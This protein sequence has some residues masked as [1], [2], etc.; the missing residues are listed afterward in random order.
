MLNIL[1]GSVQGC[2]RAGEFKHEELFQNADLIIRA[3]A[4]KYS[5]P[6]NDPQ[7]ITTGKPDSVI[8]F[9]IV[10]TLSGKG[11]SDKLTLAG[12]L[13]DKDDFNDVPVPY[14]F[15]RHNGRGGSCFANTY[16]QGAQFLLFLKKTDNGYTTNIS[17]LGPTN[18]QLR[19]EDDAWLIWVRNYLK[20]SDKPVNNN[21]LGVYIP[22][23]RRHQGLS[24]FDLFPF[25]DRQKGDPDRYRA[26][27][28]KHVKKENGSYYFLLDA[29][30]DTHYFDENSVDKGVLT[31]K[32]V[33]IDLTKRKTLKTNDGKS[34]K[35]VYVKDKGYVLDTSLA[36]SR[37]EIRIGKWYKF[38][39]KKGE[40]LLYDGT[41]I[42]RG[43]LDAES[44][45]LNYGQQK[46]I[47]GESY[48]YAFATQIIVKETNEVSGA[49]G[50]IKASAIE[51]GNDPQY[52][53]EVVEKMEPPSITGDSFSEYEVTGGNPLERVG[54]D[55]N[56][57]PI[58]KFGYADEKGEFVSYKVLPKVDLEKDKH[59]AATDY[60]KRTD[61]IINFGYNVAGVSNDTFRVKGANRP[62]IF[63][64]AAQ[65]D[66]TAV[67]DL[68]YPKTKKQSGAQPIGKMI[69]VYGYIDTP[70]GKRWGWIPIDALKPKA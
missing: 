33:K 31:E 4:V 3:T 18:E 48:Y 21:D 43:K 34:L 60:I 62:L 49:S 24:K 14:K 67:I 8:E 23:D 20:S 27:N 44:V 37:E 41:G 11:V 50:W 29:K 46:T 66:A 26:V 42:V 69:F 63:H 39:L 51:N 13:S 6:P 10:E 53:A 28:P 32:I 58:Y 52:S 56:G 19:S 61:E 36:N 54:N 30:P 68:F 12:Y 25:T 17:A 16:K 2:S 45:K 1:V 70:S 15:V 7:I 55:K 59:V 57:K 40:N 64:R 5:K 9:E 47:N 38:P 22:N 65:K 35:Y